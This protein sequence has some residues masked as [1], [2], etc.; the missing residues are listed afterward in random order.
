MSN[1]SGTTTKYL[2]DNEYK[3]HFENKVEKAL[4]RAL[5]TRKFEIELYWK[6]AT[7]FWTFL[8][9]TLAGF[10]VAYASTSPYRRDLLVILCC[11]GS[12]FSVAWFCV[13]KG[14]K[15][16]QENW[17]KHVDLLEDDV[18]GPLHKFVLSRN[19]EMTKKE[20]ML[21]L[22]TGPHPYSVS[23]IN[24][25]ISLFMVF[26]WFGLL[27]YVLQPFG[28]ELGINWFYV[29]LVAI[30]LTCCLLFLRSS[31]SYFGGHYH[32]ATLRKSRINPLQ[33]KNND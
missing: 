26:L 8:G 5:D 3:S 1:L 24:Q 18:T 21:D 30:S 16:W 19:M 29:F 13:N 14:S 15:F 17:E 25:L 12:V 9:A 2:R 32:T 28:F 31:R 27:Y 4:D 6:R 20:W 33:E 7:Y 23:K 10:F 11:L 22:A